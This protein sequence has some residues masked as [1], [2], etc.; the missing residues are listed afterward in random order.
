MKP[1]IFKKMRLILI[2]AVVTSAIVGC[3]TTTEEQQG[4]ATRAPSKPL[5]EHEVEAIVVTGSRR[6]KQVELMDAVTV[7]MPK[8]TLPKQPIIDGPVQIFKKY[9]VNPTVSTLE[10]PVSTFAMD[11]DTAS[12]HLAK[13]MLQQGLMPAEEGI[14]IEE[15]INAFDYQK[16]SGDELFNVGA[17]AF[18]SPNRPGFHTLHLSLQT[19]PLSETEKLDNN[20]VLLADTSGS[21]T[22]EKIQLLKDAFITLV[23][24][25]NRNDKIAI[26][27]YSDEATVLLSPTLVKNKRKIIRRINKMTSGGSTN[28]E[29]GIKLAY[30]MAE[31]MF[32]PGFNNRVLLTSDGMANVGSVN[33]QE[34]VTKIERFKAKGIFLTTVGVG[35]DMYNDYLLEQLA[36]LGNGHYLYFANEGDI[37]NAF[38]DELHK[39]LETV[40]KDAKIQVHFDPNVVS[41]YRLLG[42]EN[43]EVPDHQFLSQSAD[44]GEIG[45]G[46]VV[47]AIYEVKLKSQT[48]ALGQVSVAYK[49]PLGN[50]VRFFE[51]TLS[52]V[53]VV[54][55]ISKASSDSR[56]ALITSSFAEKLRQ[57]Y[58][59]Q[60]YHYT[61][62]LKQINDLP[63]HYQSQTQVKELQELIFK[64]SQLDQRESPYKVADINFD[65]DRVPALD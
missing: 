54:D 44:G 29:A 38:I 6:S 16:L 4:A 13:Q 11:V 52:P 31:Q 10:D 18:P 43:R 48:K 42:Y 64:A 65:F 2:S 12:Y 41:E 32:N 8:P 14:R 61:D 22:G 53:I 50:K 55:N 51:K 35:Q 23:S 57:S 3:G 9:R 5:A 15:F 37:Q 39:Q 17:Q 20:L 34:L 30:E 7:P 25:L 45:G 58:W 47:N 21:M 24:Q 27:T 28:A 36:N 56:L 62:L 59:A 63:K 1:T 46:H 33:A 19:N 40:A 26:V 60:S 49:K